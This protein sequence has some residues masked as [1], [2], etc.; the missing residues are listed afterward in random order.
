MSLHGSPP[1]VVIV[2]VLVLVLVLVLVVRLVFRLTIIVILVMWMMIIWL[3]GYLPIVE[4]GGLDV[5]VED[6]FNLRINFH[7]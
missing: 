7:E 5:F 3:R 6:V 4:S 1:V 2:V